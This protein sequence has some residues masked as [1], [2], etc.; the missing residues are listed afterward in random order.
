MH[1]Y[2]FW[3]TMSCLVTKFKLI[4]MNE[5]NNNERQ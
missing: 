2:S 1:K 5:E 4:K 3:K